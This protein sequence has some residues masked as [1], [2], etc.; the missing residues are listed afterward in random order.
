MPGSTHQA[1]Y[2][3]THLSQYFPSSAAKLEKVLQL[4]GL[5]ATK[6]PVQ[7]QF[8]AAEATKAPVQ[9]RLGAAGAT[10]ALV[11]GELDPIRPLKS[12]FQSQQNV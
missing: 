3:Q 1:I 11:Q 8:G 2:G 4:A 6:A 5:E 9:V 10:K 7:G 12:P